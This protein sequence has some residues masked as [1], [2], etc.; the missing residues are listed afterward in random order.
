MIVCC[1]CMV[2]VYFQYAKMSWQSVYCLLVNK[3]HWLMFEIV[4]QGLIYIK[5]NPPCVY[6]C[7]TVP[8]FEIM[9]LNSYFFQCMNFVNFTFLCKTLTVHKWGLKVFPPPKMMQLC[10]TWH[11]EFRLS[12]ILH[13]IHRLYIKITYRLKSKGSSTVLI[14]L[15]RVLLLLKVYGWSKQFFS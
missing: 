5:P 13:H 10:V 7:S 3:N 12:Q 11:H 8:S 14:F 9:S 1:A 2:L 4:I 6:L 15:T